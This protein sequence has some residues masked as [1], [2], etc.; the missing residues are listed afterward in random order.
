MNEDLYYLIDFPDCQEY[1]E[2]PD[3]TDQ[4]SACV[5]DVCPTGV[6]IRYNEANFMKVFTQRRNFY[7]NLH[8]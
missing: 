2:H 6:F 4:V 1:M 7:K 5:N 3:Y 8:I